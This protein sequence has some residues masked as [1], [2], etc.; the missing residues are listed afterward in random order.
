M[1]RRSKRG[2]VFYGCSRY[3]DCDYATWDKPIPIPC[4]RC[5]QLFLVEKRT[6]KDGRFLACPN[7]GCGYRQDPEAGSTD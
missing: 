4:P 6:K 1:E 3:P 2:K 5:G 7:A